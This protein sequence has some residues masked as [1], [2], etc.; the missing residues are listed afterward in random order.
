MKNNMQK[1]RK[2]TRKQKSVCWKVGFKWNTIT[3]TKK[4]LRII[5]DPRAFTQ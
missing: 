1:Q 4:S 2:Q 3:S 5:P